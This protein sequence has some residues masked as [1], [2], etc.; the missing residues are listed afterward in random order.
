M[1][2]LKTLLLPALALSLSA[3]A[4]V[5]HASTIA[6][7]VDGNCGMCKKTIESAAFVKGE[8]TAIWERNT[9]IATI[10][11]DSTRTDPD[12]VLKRIALA[13]YDNQS[14][15]APADAYAALPGCCQYDRNRKEPAMNPEAMADAPHAE[16][17]AAVEQTTQEE[18]DP[19]DPVFSSYFELK[20]ALV[21][22]D[23]TAATAQAKALGE[24]L[25]GV[26]MD[27]LST[28]AHSAWM[29]LMKPLTAQATMIATAKDIAA[30]RKAFA[31]L[32]ERMEELL[33]ASPR[34]TPVYVVHC[35]MY[36]GGADWLSLEA[37]IKNPFYGSKMLTCG[38]VTGTIV[39]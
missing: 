23:A 35:P 7:E 38:K 19:L 2:I 11:Y 28:K 13:G 32:S 15:L 10:T 5:K 33:T 12:A 8:A 18:N 20:D 22:S 26:R 17:E 16:M 29:K 3:F 1:K 14:Y 4:Q 6:L 24:A 34:A 25:G 36:E 21:V 39:K 37:P 9:K 31:V 30:Q 27:A